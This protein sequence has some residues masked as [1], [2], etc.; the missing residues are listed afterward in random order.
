MGIIKRLKE[1]RKRIAD[2]RN[3]YCCRLI[4]SLS[5]AIAEANSFF[6]DNDVFIDPIIADNWK[7]KH[8]QLIS[9]SAP[10]GVR[11]LKKAVSYKELVSSE[12]SARRLFISIPSLVER[13]NDTVSK[14]KLKEA[15][16]LILPVEGRTLDD[17]QLKAIVNDAHNHLIIAG[18]GSGKTTTI[19][20]KVKYLIKSGKCRPEDILVLSF[21][22]SSAAEMAKRITSEVGHGVEAST[23]HKLGL[24]I[25][26]KVEGIKPK[27]SNLSLYRFIKDK[28]RTLCQNED[29]LL[30]FVTYFSMYRIQG[31][32]EFEFGSKEEYEDYL[33]SNPPLTIK[34]ERVKSYGELDI[35]NYLFRNGIDYQ[36]EAPFFVDTRSSEYGEYHPDF[37][38]PEYGIYIEYFG[39]NEAGMVPSWFT[40]KNGRTASETYND[41]I[42][43]KRAIHKQHGSILLEC[44]SYEKANGSL[45]NNLE[46]KLKEKGV[47]LVPKSA[48][49][50]WGAI[51]NG[52]N[53][54]DGIVELIETIINLLK[55]N[56]YSIAQ[57]RQIAS[58]SLVNTARCSALIDLVEPIFAAYKQLLKENN[59]IDF[60]DMI[61]V[62]AS[63]V[64][65]NKYINP[66]S[67]VLIDEYQDISRSRYSLLR[68]LRASKDYDLFCVGDDW[69]SIFRFAGSDIDFI[70]R[71]DRYWGPS[72]ISRIEKTYRFSKSLI[73]VSGSFIMRNPNQIRK[74][75]ISANND[76]RFSVGIING[77]N[78]KS[79]VNFMAARIDEIPKCSSV[80]IIGRYSFDDALLKECGLFDLRFNNQSETNEVKYKKRPDLQIRFLTAHKSKGLQADYVFVINNKKSRM[81]FP[82]R[83]LDDPII[84]LLLGNSDSFPHSEERRLFYVALT[85]AK[86]KT[87]LLTVRDQES[88][89]IAEINER[90]STQLQKEQYECPIC[91]GR[92]VKRDG[93][94]GAF[95]GC[96]NYRKTGCSFIRKIPPTKKR[97]TE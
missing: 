72:S 91:G 59:E 57:L 90:F 14:K 94:Y 27:I 50:I 28:F 35:A 23:F 70:L 25:I 44:Y 80:F 60:N 78:E 48:K 1:R 84:D 45:L 12:S 31:K 68:A 32:S 34:N 40:G 74:N 46:T 53:I 96:S 63:Y 61:N 22:N 9:V 17:Q 15:G 16:D 82:C 42:A 65:A 43:W 29:Y 54:I 49:E 47:R 83:I 95:L 88:I 36:Y 38:L 13:H 18:A 87:Y 21:T 73:D 5:A 76:Q 85:R 67:Y 51:D 89:F 30:A 62:A 41:S 77:Y 79:A 81:G 7:T 71:F 86:I 24:N 66:Y 4:A 33:T 58:S 11:S 93:P 20:G 6:S 55:S 10:N 37:Y 75:L 64:N 56:D 52:A 19:V 97:S 92:L 2:E 8:H 39:I 69:Q 26:T 3:S